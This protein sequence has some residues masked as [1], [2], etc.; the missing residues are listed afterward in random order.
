VKPEDSLKRLIAVIANSK[1]NTFP[2]INEKREL[3]GL[4]HLDNI[5]SIIF[6]SDHPEDVFVKSLMTPPA[7]IIHVNEN[8]HS[9]LLKFDETSLW[10]LPVVDHDQYLGFVSKSTLLSKYRAELLK[11]V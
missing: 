2:V 7:A 8:L 4:V 9:V 10:N 6:S 3:L 1:R 11:S 5:R